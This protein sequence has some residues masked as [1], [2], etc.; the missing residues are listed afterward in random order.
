MNHNIIFDT[1]VNHQTKYERVEDIRRELSE[2][3]E[4]L[5]EKSS[6]VNVR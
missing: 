6:N 4:A 2:K 3:E 5:R 1:M